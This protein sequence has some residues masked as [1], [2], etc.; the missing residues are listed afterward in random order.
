MSRA[1][2][3]CRTRSA[4]SAIAGIASGCSAPR[5]KLLTSEGWQRWVSVRSRGRVDTAVAAYHEGPRPAGKYSGCVRERHV[6]NGGA[7]RR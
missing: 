5:E 1:R 4:L 6:I 2:A 3:G 7:P